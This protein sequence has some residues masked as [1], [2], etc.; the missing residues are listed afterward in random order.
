M[1]GAFERRVD[2]QT[3][4]EHV[5]GTHALVDAN[6]LLIGLKLTPGRATDG[7]SV[8]EVFN[9]LTKGDVVL[10]DRAYDSDA[11]RTELTN[12]IGSCTKRR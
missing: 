3:R 2:Y 6:G 7:R 10:V 11:L 1:Y 12:I 4:P 9:T 8:A 5:E